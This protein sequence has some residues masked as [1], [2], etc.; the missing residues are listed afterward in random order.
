MSSSKIR[1]E[2]RA[3]AKAQELGTTRQ[4][5]VEFEEVGLAVAQR[6]VAGGGI[7]TPIQH[8]AIQIGEQV[9]HQF[10]TYVAGGAPRTVTVSA[11][12]PAGWFQHVLFELANNALNKSFTSAGSRFGLWLAGKVKFDT[13]SNSE[14]VN[15]LICPHIN[16]PNHHQAHV[17]FLVR[18]MG[19]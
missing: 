19:Q 1:R 11:K 7:T 4:V 10:R 14:E 8:E 13:V 6:Q 16:K 2:A 17:Q 18:E 15:R 3:A 9:I 12:A 5:T